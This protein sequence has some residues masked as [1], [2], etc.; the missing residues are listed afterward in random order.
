MG[1]TP[2]PIGT[3][4]LTWPGVPTL[5]R[6]CTGKTGRKKPCGNSTRHPSGRCQVHR[7]VSVAADAPGDDATDVDPLDDIAVTAAPAVPARATK[8]APPAGTPTWAAKSARPSHANDAVQSVAD[9]KLEKLAHLKGR[10]VVL[11]DLDGTVY[12]P[13]ACCKKSDHSLTGSET[14]RH[15]RTDTTEHIKRICDEQ[16]AVP[17]ILSWRGGCT[18]KS[19]TWLQA[20]GFDTAAEFI[21]GSDHDISGLGLPWTAGG[22]VDHSAVRKT[23][24]GGQVGFKATTVQMLR[25]HLDVDIVASFEDNAKVLEAMEDLG[26]PTRVQVERAVKIESWEWDAGYIGAPRPA[27]A[28]T[29]ECVDCNQ[30]FDDT[31]TRRDR[32]HRRCCQS[33][34]QVR[35]D[36]SRK[37]RA[38]TGWGGKPLSTST[39]SSAPVGHVPGQRTLPM[40]ESSCALC[41]G[42]AD[43]NEQLCQNCYWTTRFSG[44]ALYDSP[45]QVADGPASGFEDLFAE[46]DEVWTT[47]GRAGTVVG[48]DEYGLVMIRSSHDGELDWVHGDDLMSVPF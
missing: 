8:V 41:H 11:V 36:A 20:V 3:K 39:T 12:D 26:V 7:T 14:C 27:W 44:A 1:A 4:P 43:P 6:P 48:H 30:P 25:E 42:P 29:N 2:A 38:T 16:D 31:N 37:S 28:D 19:R 45:P 23:W 9:I 17:V 10:K 46:G 32:V 21:P 35:D 15:L 47:E 13:W 18:D 33:C 22:K 40:R 5:S 24:G 34:A